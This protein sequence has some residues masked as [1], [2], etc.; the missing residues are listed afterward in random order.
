MQKRARVIT[1]SL[2]LALAACGGSGGSNGGGSSFVPV[3]PQSATSTS[4]PSLQTS[5]SIA[6]LF[7]GGFTIQTGTSHGL[8]DVYTNASTVF[9]GAAPFVGEQVTVAG[10]GSF[11]TSITA[12]TVTQTVA[13]AGAPAP[14]AT[15]NLLTIGGPVA[16]ISSKGVQLT[17]S[18]HGL[19]WIATTSSTAYF[20][21]AP[22]VGDYE[23]VAGTGSL[24]TSYGFTA[25]SASQTATAP[26][27]ATAS[28]TVVAGTSYGFTLDVNSTYPAVPIVLSTSSVVAG[29]TLEVG[30]QATVTG[31][32]A[33]VTSITAVTVVIVDPTPVASPTPTPTPIAQTHIL[34]ADYLGAPDG[35]TSVTGARAAP[36]LTWAQ[37]GIADASALSAA[38]IK[39]Q[40]YYDP[41]RVQTNNALYSAPAS[42][43]AQSCGGTD[44]TDYFDSVTQYVMNPS[45][46]ALQTAYAADVKAYVGT[47][48]FD[49]IYQDDSGPLSEISTAFSPSMP[50]NYSD[51]AW[52]TGGIALGNA[53]PYPVVFNGL[54]VLD[55]ESV[56]MSIGLLGSGS[57][58]TIGGN[59]EG[60]YSTTNQPE[61]DG[62]LWA[63][64]E[65][66]ELEVNADNKQFWCQERNVAD[67]SQ[68]VASRIYAYASFLLTYNPSLDVLWEDFGTSS[69]LH[70]FPEEQLVA[71]D[72]VIA[73][74]GSVSSLEQ[75]GGAY[76]RQ[77]SECF[78]AGKFVGPC[79][80]AIN[81]NGSGSV[82]FPYPQYTHT[83]TLG[84]YGVLDGGTIATT[85]GAPPEYLGSL[86]AEIVF[87]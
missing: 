31:T 74:P 66:T 28:G 12:T 48:H 78:I 84:G 26:V 4:S 55:G 38:G 5:G 79:A 30:S 85:G 62:W 70:V 19:L 43:F 42:A 36:Y 23:S 3:M 2:V 25:V 39:T 68:S 77:Y 73:A 32:G 54:G 1:F 86:Q 20:G 81:P 69:G 14:I 76:G 11:S 87:P 61:N 22:S 33:T 50:C 17:T 45:S 59:F 47:A 53:A 64:E 63:T 71:L 27:T 49:S 82:P 58:N 72:P 34:T 13:G 57:T 16:A 35:T 37:T 60:C 52:I 67:A 24:S 21:G 15:P 75:S 8:L 9:T 6:A 56:S 29:G 65:N 46:T 51:S 7:A 44:V 18:A 80:V 40:L 10:T 41:N 83:L